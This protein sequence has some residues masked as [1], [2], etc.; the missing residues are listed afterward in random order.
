MIEKANDIEHIIAND[1]GQSIKSLGKHI[2]NLHSLLAPVLNVA[3]KMQE[4][5]KESHLQEVKTSQHGLWQS[6]VCVNAQTSIIHTENYCSY[7]VI[8]VPNQ[9]YDGK[10][11]EFLFSFNP[12]KSVSLTLENHISFIFSGLF[13]SHKQVGPNDISEKSKCF[14]N[15]ASYGNARLF[16]NLR[17]SFKRNKT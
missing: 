3:S 8:S 12:N 6:Q 2:T 17:Q 9:E 1:L 15:L 13:L 7:T 16:N 14:Y 11:Y 5:N 10:K 4:H